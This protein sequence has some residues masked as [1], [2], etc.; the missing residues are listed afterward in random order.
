MHPDLATSPARARQLVE[1]LQ[2]QPHPEGG[3]YREVFRSSG[4]VQLADGRGARQALTSIYGFDTLDRHQPNTF[5]TA[6]P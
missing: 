4:T 6:V 5:T 3:W 2:L 1:D